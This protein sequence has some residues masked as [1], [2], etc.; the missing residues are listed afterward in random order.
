[1][2]TGVIV[3]VQDFIIN[4]EGNKIKPKILETEKDFDILFIFQNCK[5]VFKN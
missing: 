5:I 3:G 4:N 2:I 1:M